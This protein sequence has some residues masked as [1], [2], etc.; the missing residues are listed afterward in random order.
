MTPQMMLTH[1]I[2]MPALCVENLEW[3][4]SCSSDVFCV[5]D[6][7]TQNAVDG[8]LPKIIK[9]IFASWRMNTEKLFPHFHTDSV[10]I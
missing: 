6:G 3:T 4:M 1:L 5:L 9:A 10:Y 8:T 2:P 7:H